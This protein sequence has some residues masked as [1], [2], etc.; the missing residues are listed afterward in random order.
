MS[1]GLSVGSPVSLPVG[2]FDLSVGSP[3]SLPVGLP[4]A[5][6][7]KQKPPADSGGSIYHTRYYKAQSRKSQTSC[8]FHSSRD[9]S[10]REYLMTFS[11][12]H[13]LSATTNL[14]NGFENCKDCVGFFAA[15]CSFPVISGHLC[16]LWSSLPSFERRPAKTRRFF[17]DDAP[18]WG[19]KGKY[20]HRH[21][22]I[23]RFLRDNLLILKLDSLQAIYTKYGAETSGPGIPR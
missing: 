6:C 1:V 23:G 20:R 10:D 11:F 3:V 13:F 5:V 8:R 19:F 14:S 16:R 21:R 4:R 15:V 17:C 2:L 12:A 22:K 9:S 18:K 7:Q